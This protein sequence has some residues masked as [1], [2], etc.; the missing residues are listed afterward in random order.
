MTQARP[1]D[2]SALSNLRIRKQEAEDV[3]W[4]INTIKILSAFTVILFCLYT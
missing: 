4:T 2:D 1:I 3:E